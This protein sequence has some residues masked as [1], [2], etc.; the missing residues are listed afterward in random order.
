MKNCVLR[1][2]ERYWPGP[3]RMLAMVLTGAIRALPSIVGPHP[4]PPPL[5]GGPP[6]PYLGRDNLHQPWCRFLT[7]GDLHQRA[8]SEFLPCTGRGDRAKRGGRG[9]FGRCTVCHELNAVARFAGK[10]HQPD[11][12]GL[13][14]TLASAPGLL[15]EQTAE[16]RDDEPAEEGEGAYLV[17]DGRCRR[18]CCPRR[19]ARRC[20][21]ARG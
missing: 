15:A 12:R 14:R 8:C 2:R 10:D 11:A 13:R 5:R 9:P 6:S 7:G 18:G 4:R 21:G 20:G 17:R 16:E 19:C 1:R 3:P